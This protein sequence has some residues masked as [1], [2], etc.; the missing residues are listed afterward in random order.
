MVAVGRAIFE[1][2]SNVNGNCAIQELIELDR[3]GSSWNELI[4]HAS[5]VAVL[6]SVPEQVVMV[7]HVVEQLSEAEESAVTVEQ[8]VEQVETGEAEQELEED[9]VDELPD[10]GPDVADGPAEGFGFGGTIVIGARSGT[11]PGGAIGGLTGN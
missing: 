7:V 9:V 8:I 3:A 10:E 2:V 1:N 11:K 6:A 5:V 4:E